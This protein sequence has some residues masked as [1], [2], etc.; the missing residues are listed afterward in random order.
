MSR[1]L[2]NMSEER[3]ATILTTLFFLICLGGLVSLL[4]FQEQV[5]LLAMRMQQTADLATKGARA[6][7]KWE[8]VHANGEKRRILFATTREAE[9]NEANIIR[10]AREEAEMLIQRNKAA[11]RKEAVAFRVIHQK[12]E[13]AYLYR[14]GLYHVRLEASSLLDLFGEP[15]S[16]TVSKTSQ[17]GL[18][19]P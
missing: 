8:Y 13:Q 10:G 2:K 16:I 14:Q 3:G 4:L 6:A 15:A 12:G 7:G 5:G 1:W 9:R 18:Y 17:S 11:L 19:D